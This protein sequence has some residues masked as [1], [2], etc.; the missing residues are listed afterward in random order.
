MQNRNNK[1]LL[2]KTLGH[3]EA[4]LEFTNKINS[5]E[6]FR[7]NPIA[8]DI[9]ILHLGQIG[10]L[11]KRFTEDFKLEHP[12][13]DFRAIA[14]LRD[15]VVHD[16]SGIN[17]EIFSTIKNDI[18]KLK[19]DYINILINDYNVN[20]EDLNEYLINYIQTRRFIID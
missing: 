13:I 19:N 5:Y 4:I 10:E 11:C 14:G 18:V 17:Y 20:I 9:S 12:N 7:N 3:I 2:F 16:Y 15:V 8:L 6:E 1:E